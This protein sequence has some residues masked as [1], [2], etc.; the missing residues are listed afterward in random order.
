MTCLPPRTRGLFSGSPVSACQED[1]KPGR[2]LDKD[3][4]ATASRARLSP[5]TGR[6]RQALHLL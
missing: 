5:N 1:L 3:S 6:E 2:T 4:A